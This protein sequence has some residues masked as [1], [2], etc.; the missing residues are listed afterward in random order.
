MLQNSGESW[1]QQQQLQFATVTE[2]C[3]LRS[4]WIRGTEKGG[5]GAQWATSPFYHP[6]TPK[7]PMVCPELCLLVVQLTMKI[8]HKV[9]FGGGEAGLRSLS[10]Y[11]PRAA[12]GSALVVYGCAWAL[13]PTTE[14]IM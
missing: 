10:L 9:D 7:M 12:E 3:L 13:P 4:L 6:P 14:Q 8:N 1:A 5:S 11:I 2:V